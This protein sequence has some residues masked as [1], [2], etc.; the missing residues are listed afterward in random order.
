MSLVPPQFD[1]IS[2][3]YLT[4]YVHHSSSYIADPQSIATIHPAL[5]HVGPATVGGMKNVLV[6]SVPKMEWSRVSG[7]VLALLRA[8]ADVE[9]VDVLDAPKTRAKRGGEL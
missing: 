4:V 3:V 1:F 2:N 7:D 6:L 9:K 8:Q 5:A